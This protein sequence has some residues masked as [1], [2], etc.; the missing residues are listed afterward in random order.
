RASADAIVRRDEPALWP[1][2]R[3]DAADPQPPDGD[4]DSTIESTLT[5]LMPW[6]G[7]AS[8]LASALARL[9]GAR[10]PVVRVLVIELNTAQPDLVAELINAHA[11]W[12]AGVS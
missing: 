6:S 2:L 3:V 4:S 9:R 10:S 7:T 1:L 12:A 5:V 8:G 11:P